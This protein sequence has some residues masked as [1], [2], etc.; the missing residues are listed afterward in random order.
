MK[1]LAFRVAQCVIAITLAAAAVAQTQPGDLVVN[2]PFAFLAGNRQMPSGKYVV[3]R[4]SNGGLRIAGADNSSSYMFMSAHS[5]ESRA[6][7]SPK[8]VFHRYDDTYFLSEVW[9]GDGRIGRQLP[10]SKEEKEILSAKAN[11]GHAKGELAE[12][13]SER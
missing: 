9:N 11:G 4:T 6:S 8:L 10:R 7:Q 2:I 13:R 5:I 12:V 1:T 3:S